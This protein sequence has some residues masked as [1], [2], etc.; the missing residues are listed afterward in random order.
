MTRLRYFRTFWHSTCPETINRACRGCSARLR[1]F[2]E[3][4]AYKDRLVKRVS[5]HDDRRM[6]VNLAWEQKSNSILRSGN[7]VEASELVLT[8]YKNS[9]NTKNSGDGLCTCLRLGRTPCGC[10]TWPRSAAIRMMINDANNIDK[11]TNF[12]SNSCNSNRGVEPYFPDYPESKQ[13]F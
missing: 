12:S 1:S 13:C 6:K 3:G 11:K 9:K 4:G 8:F 5:V 10:P 7:N 2:R